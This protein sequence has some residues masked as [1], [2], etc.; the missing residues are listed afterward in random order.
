MLL[1]ILQALYFFLPAYVA[2]MMPVFVRKVPFLQNPVWAKYL[3]PNKTW[4]GVVAATLAGGIVFLIQ[5]VLYRSG[6]D[7]LAFI[8]YADIP[9]YFGLLMGFGA[10]MGDLVKSYY[11]RKEGIPA[12]EHWVPFDQMDFAIGG[13][14][15]ACLL[16]V[17]PV[18]VTVVILLVSP[19]LH[20]LVNY[21][22]YMMKVRKKKY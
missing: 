1:L 10:I 22:G 11:K 7:S 19:L 9:I 2:N 17:P 18:E 8:D 13:L 4:R 3:G 20:L 16:Y 21:V 15:G 14:I 5:Q 6:F 12:G